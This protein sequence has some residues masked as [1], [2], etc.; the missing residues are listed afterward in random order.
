MVFVGIFFVEMRI[1]VIYFECIFRNEVFKIFEDKIRVMNFKS[2]NVGMVSSGLVGLS[3]GDLIDSL[4][5]DFVVLY[6]DIGVV[7]FCEDFKVLMNGNNDY[8]VEVF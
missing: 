3:S 6:Y 4:K 1:E 7:K 8:D 5:N 2:R